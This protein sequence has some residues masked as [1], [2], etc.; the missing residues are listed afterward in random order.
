MT[1]SLQYGSARGPE[2]GDPWDKLLAVSES[3]VRETEQTMSR[4]YRRAA[5]NSAQAVRLGGPHE[6]PAF[7]TLLSESERELEELCAG[8]DYRQMLG[9]TTP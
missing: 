7:E 4:A 3:A 6:A 1:I 2:S 5:L 9:R 8:H